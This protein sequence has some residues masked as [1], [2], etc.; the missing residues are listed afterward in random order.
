VTRIH[1]TPSR[2][3]RFATRVLFL[4]F[5]LLAAGCPFGSD[6]SVDHRPKLTL[7]EL[8]AAPETLVVDGAKIMA[9]ASVWRD[10][11]PTTPPAPNGSEL[12]GAI[13]LVPVDPTFQASTPSKLFVWIVHGSE[14]WTGSLTHEGVGS[15]GGQR[16]TFVGGP[17]WDTGSKVDVIV[18]IPSG[19]RTELVVDRDANIMR[20][21]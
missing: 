11:M 2:A 16:Y 19:R 7:D 5:P 18:G 20:T 17:R 10:Y 3:I 6:S 12:R 13:D 8:R 21:E 9:Q 4:A 15:S 14:I 1:R